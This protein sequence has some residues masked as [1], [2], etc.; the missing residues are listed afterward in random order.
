MPAFDPRCASDFKRVA[1]VKRHPNNPKETQQGSDAYDNTGHALD[2]N[3]THFL[4]VDA[5]ANVSTSMN[6]PS[7]QSINASN[8]GQRIEMSFRK[9]LEAAVQNRDTL[10]EM[11]LLCV[12]LGGGE[13]TYAKLL[14]VLKDDNPVI[15]IR[16]SGG[17][18]EKVARFVEWAR[19]LGSDELTAPSDKVRIAARRP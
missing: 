11:P 16:G 2:T 18:A 6:N 3:H 1:Y 19:G 17:C 13:A 8:A 15:I 14:E 5:P 12:V 7:R 9:T 4:L 10:W